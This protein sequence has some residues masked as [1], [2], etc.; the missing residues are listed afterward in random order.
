HLKTYIDNF[1]KVYKDILPKWRGQLNYFRNAGEIID[2]VFNTSIILPH[3]ITY[4][5][6]NVKELKNPHSKDVLKIA[7]SCCEETE[8][9]FFFIATLLKESAE[10]TSKDTAEIFMG[11]KELRDKKILIPIEISTIEPQAVSQQEI[12]LINQKVSSLSNLT[13]EEKQKLVTELAQMSPMQRE[14]Y[15]S[16]LMSRQQIISAPVKMK[17]G[18][19]EIENQ[20]SAKRELNELLKRAK[21]AKGKKNNEKAIE[22]LQNAAMVASS[23]K[24]TNDFIKVEEYI[25]KIKI[26]DLL[27]NKNAIEQKA[28][29]AAKKKNYQ[30]AAN[31]YKVASKIASEIF[32]LGATEMTKE[33]KRLTNKANEYEKLK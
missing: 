30:D 6:S 21:I 22:Y 24:L 14:A 4:D 19:A 28:K 20:K 3:Q 25:R 2:E 23:W 13:S 9:E 7:H 18:T 15:L 5:F 27:A 12:N 17:I 29:E 33:V 16:S 32:K 31:S 11:V 1:E 10:K 26:E 8:R